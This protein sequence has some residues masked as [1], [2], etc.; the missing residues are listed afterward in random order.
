MAL[1]HFNHWPQH[2][3]LAMKADFTST[4]YAKPRWKT[5]LY[6]YKPTNKDL[7]ELES[8]TWLEF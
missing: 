1:C 6:G 8:T 4:P 5:R 7:I 2:L 3:K